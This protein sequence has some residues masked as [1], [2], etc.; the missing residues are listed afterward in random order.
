MGGV[1]CIV[2]EMQRVSHFNLLSIRRM[3][4]RTY[5]CILLKLP[6]NYCWE[7]ENIPSEEEAL[8]LANVPPRI[9]TLKQS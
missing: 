3:M 4:F 8:V 9:N 6:S 7:T 2:T 1:Y 5:P